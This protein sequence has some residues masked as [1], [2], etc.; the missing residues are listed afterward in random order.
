LACI[1]KT[2][3]LVRIV[4]IR[5]TENCF[6]L[7]NLASQFKYFANL[8]KQADAVTANTSTAADYCRSY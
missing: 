4:R 7:P 5:N 2:I 1:V 3:I 6:V 8:D